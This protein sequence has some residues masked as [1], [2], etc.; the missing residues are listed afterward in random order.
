MGIISFWCQPEMKSTGGA[1]EWDLLFI[2]L[3]L[4]WQTSTQSWGKRLHLRPVRMRSCTWAVVDADVAAGGS[5]W[6][7]CIGNEDGS[8]VETVPW[9][10]CGRQR[11]VR[12]LWK[13]NLPIVSGSQTWSGR[14][15]KV[16]HT[17]SEF[18]YASG[19]TP[20]A[21]EEAVYQPTKIEHAV[22]CGCVW[23]PFLL[24]QAAI[25]MH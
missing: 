5:V 7:A 2:Y 1:G 18:D 14:L 9:A 13:E 12:M 15:T 4:K 23:K 11:Y 25:R 3:C 16:V 19:G 17:G 22:C 24:R 6:E 8:D 10:A 21:Q 20:W